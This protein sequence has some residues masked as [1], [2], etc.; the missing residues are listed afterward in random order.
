MIQWYDFEPDFVVDISHTIDKKVA[1]ILAYSTQFYDPNSK[2]PETPISSKNFLESVKYRAQNMGR[3]TGVD[4]AE[5][6]TVQ[7]Y[8][9]INSLFDIH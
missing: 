9:L 1:S 5:G 7:R 4:Y 6:F 2:E 8:P 3:I